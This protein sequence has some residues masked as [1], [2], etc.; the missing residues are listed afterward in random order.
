MG[1]ICKVF[2]VVAIII[3]LLVAGKKR[4]NDI[5]DYSVQNA[6]WKQYMAGNLNGLFFALDILQK[7]V[8]VFYMLDI[9]NQFTEKSSNIVNGNKQ[10]RIL[11]LL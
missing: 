10:E 6:M 9:V 1:K 8:I 2:F 3:S 5:V 11:V 4:N 7:T